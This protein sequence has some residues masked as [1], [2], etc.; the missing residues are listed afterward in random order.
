ML[1]A[2][3]FNYRVLITS[4]T[5][6]AIDHAI[7][8]LTTFFREHGLCQWLDEQRVVCFG[9]PALTGLFSS[10]QKVLVLPG[11]NSERALYLPD[12]FMSSTR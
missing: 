2:L 7:D 5:N 11:I 9:G 1:H 3:Y 8:R 4:H 12:S 10:P 6:V